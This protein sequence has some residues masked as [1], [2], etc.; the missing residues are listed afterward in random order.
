MMEPVHR[1]DGV[2]ASPV[3]GRVVYDR[4]KM[5]WNLSIIAGAVVFAPLTFSWSMFLI[6]IVSTYLTLLIGH[7]VGLHRMMIHRAFDGSKTVERLLI[8]IGVIVGMAGPFGVVRIHDQRDWA[9]RQPRCHQF[10]SHKAGFIK[11]LWWQLTCHFEFDAPPRFKIESKFADDQFLQ[12]LE[13]TWRLHQLVLA[14]V[15]F[16]VGGWALVVWGVFARV[17]ISI[18][19]HWTITYFCHNP[20]A[21]RWAVKGA[22]VQASN[23]PGLGVLTYGECWHNNHHAFPESA[24]IGL[25]PG[26]TD[27]AWWLICVLNR[28][29]WVFN[30]KQPR[31]QSQ[32]ED[33]VNKY[34]Q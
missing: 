2:D 26:Q 1:I 21:G 30:V 5:L 16:L 18:V 3:R 32:R 27:P 13:S 4:P 19:G 17:A 22:S 28:L 23:L 14:I 24:R 29:G 12:G 33:L 20:G 10:F 6:F 7:S 15:L 8:Y 31:D 34:W 11:D 25:E 9:Q